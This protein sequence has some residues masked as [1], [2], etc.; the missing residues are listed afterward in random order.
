MTF[1]ANGGTLNTPGTP[2]TADQ[3]G[4]YQVLGGI[5]TPAKGGSAYFVQSAVVQTTYNPAPGQFR[6]GSLGR[7]IAS[8]PGYVNLDASIF[9]IV[10]VK[11]SVK[12]EIRG[13][14]FGVTNTPQFNRPNTDV[15]NSNY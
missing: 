9:K 5:N 14:A 13:E 6:L 1:T 15:S 2:A 12:L 10:H 8:G 11:E 4:P 7:N 3:V